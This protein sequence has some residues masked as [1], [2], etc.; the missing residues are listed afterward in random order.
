MRDGGR[1]RIGWSFGKPR[2]CPE[3]RGMIIDQNI[4]DELA[5]PF[6]SV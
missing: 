6:S 2:N 4:L 5:A 1:M 3:G